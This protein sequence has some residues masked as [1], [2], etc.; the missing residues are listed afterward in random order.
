VK[1]GTRKC[2]TSAGGTCAIT[3]PASTKKGTLVAKASQNGYG[4]GS[5]RLKVT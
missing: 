5:V 2:T 1:V 4:A 3:F